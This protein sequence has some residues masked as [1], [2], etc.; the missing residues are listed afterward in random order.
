MQVT[1]PTFDSS[2]SFDCGL[3]LKYL[4]GEGNEENIKRRRKGVRNS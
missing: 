1:I 2:S 4:G 3:N